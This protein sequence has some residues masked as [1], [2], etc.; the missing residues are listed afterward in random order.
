MKNV[1]VIGGGIIGLSSAFYLQQSGCKVT[2]IDKDNFKDNCSYGNAGYVCPSHFIPLAAPGIIWQ[3]FKWMFNSQSPFYVKPSL[4]KDL[5]DW[6]FNF[7]RSA[8]NK[9][10]L[11][12]AIPLRDISLLSQHEFEKWTKIP[13]FN[14]AYEHKGMLEVFQTEAV[15]HHAH[16]TVEK[17]KQLGLDVSL[18][19][20]Q[21]LQ[22]LEPQTNINAIGAVKYDCDAHVYPD[23]L[24]DGLKKML[25]ANGVAFK[26]GES[27]QSFEKNN[28]V[29][30]KVITKENAY[31][32]DDVVI[33][34]GSWSKE[35]AELAGAKIS[36]MPGRGYSLTLEDSPYKLNHP[37]IL[38][39]GRV[40]I[41]PMD[42]NKIRFGGTME[43]VPTTAKPQYER[44]NGVI[45]SVKQFLPEFQIE[46]PA[47][48][49]I[50]C[51][52]RP[53][54]ADGVP[55]IGKIKKHKNVVV[56]TGHSMMGLSLGPGTGKLVSEIINEVP[57]SIDIKA[58]E[59]ER[60]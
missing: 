58:F 60:F 48:E 18:L 42:G 53:C 14:F 17:A 56:A 43:V 38:A 47:D 40:A 31:P 27:V 15:A 10:V 19:N 51:G 21:E 59:A 28:S 35:I 34:T 30:T 25:L 54:S 20:Y 36:L 29:V 57:T 5:I 52:F 49:K 41:T 7:A 45:N 33:A 44:I 50:W 46:K 16:H 26:Y 22:D 6:G 3:G 11:K 37:M 12:S 32:A 8:T 9:N 23:R 2:V 1:V 55:Y 39:E 4:N 24:M 13:D